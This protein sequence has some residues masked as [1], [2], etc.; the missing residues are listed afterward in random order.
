VRDDLGTPPPLDLLTLTECPSQPFADPTDTR[1]PL[2]QL[3]R[4]LA[5]FLASHGEDVYHPSDLTRDDFTAD[6]TPNELL[7]GPPPK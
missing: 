6:F 7:D 4:E 5:R 3:R 1:T 2:V